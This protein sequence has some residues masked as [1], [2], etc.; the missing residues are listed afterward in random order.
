MRKLLLFANRNGFFYVLDRATGKFLSGKPFAKVTWATGLDETGRPRF[1]TPKAGEATYPGVQGA[2]NWYSPSF[3]P[4]TGL[5]YLSAWIDYASVFYAEHTVYREGQGFWGG[6]VRPPVPGVP[7]P[8]IGTSPINRRTD[9]T[10]HGAVLALDVLT[11]EKKW[12]HKMHDVTDAGIL[13]TASDLVFT[14]GREGYFHA[15][16]ARTGKLLWKASVGGTV[17]AAP[18]TYQLDGRQYVAIAAGHALFVYGLRE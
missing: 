9:T 5:F 15:L 11:G 3:S 16:D 4:R 7:S 17:A 14:G 2:T 8:S 13:T 10:G 6:G 18:I 1:T 12:E